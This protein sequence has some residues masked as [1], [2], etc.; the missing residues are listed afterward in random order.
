MHKDNN[1]STI[2]FVVWILC[3]IFFMYEFLLR[4]VVGTFQS[5]ITYDL[6]LNSFKFSI[7]STSAYLGIYGIMQLPVGII[8]DSLELK[9]SVFIG[10]AICAI[11]AILFSL[12]NSFYFAIPARM[13]MG[14]GSSFGFICL[15]VAV[16]DW[17]PKKNLALFIGLSQFIGTIGPM[18]AA[19]PLNTIAESAINTTWRDIFYYLGLFG[20]ALSA[21]LFFFVRNN[22]IK[23]GNYII[24]RKHEPPKDRIRNIFFRK[25]PWLIAIYS[26]CVYFS[27][28]YLSENE[29]KNFIMLKGYSSSFASYM[30]TLSW[31]GYA[32]GCPAIGLISD[33]LQRRKS[34]LIYCSVILSLSLIGIYLSPSQIISSISFFCLGIG[35][36]GQSVGF[37][38]IAENFKKQYLAVGLSLNNAMITTISAI[39]APCIGFLLESYKESVDLIATDYFIVFAILTAVSLISVFIS[40]FCIKENFCKSK[41]ELTQLNPS[42]NN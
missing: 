41:V 18:S 20:F 7:I 12:I 37:A 21:L 2:G 34:V 30:I 17:F 33:Y 5:P 26:A 16:Y 15:L 29:S 1:F 13:L 38:L 23:S 8:V 10:C 25:E 3:A 24:L 11:S 4:T 36:S 42:Y 22:N 28:E 40:I 31:V 27:I 32:I 19:G 35:A 39:N 9:K 6:Q 14:L